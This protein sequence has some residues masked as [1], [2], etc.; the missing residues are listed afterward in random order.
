[1]HIEQ[2]AYLSLPSNLQVQVIVPLIMFTT[3]EL[4]EWNPVHKCTCRL[5]RVI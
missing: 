1:M 5:Y 2:T 4:Q 3:V